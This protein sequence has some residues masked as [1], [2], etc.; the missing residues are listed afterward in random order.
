MPESGHTWRK[1]FKGEPVEA[2]HVRLWTAGRVKHPDAPLIADELFV[3]VLGSGA[4]VVEMTLSTSDTR[5]RITALG[6]DPLPLLYSHG[7]GWALVAGLS[8]SAG[9]TT[10]ECGLWAQ[11]GARR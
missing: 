4:P 5:I 2:R 8:H 10:D 7:P 11:L 1:A 6:P 3:A 9:L